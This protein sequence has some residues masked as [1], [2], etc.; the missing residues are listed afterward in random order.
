MLFWDLQNHYICLV[1]PIVAVGSYM[2][3]LC[4]A[5]LACKTA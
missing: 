2:L 1:L 5:T 3:S 4:F